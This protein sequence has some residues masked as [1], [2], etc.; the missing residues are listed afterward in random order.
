MPDVDVLLVGG[1]VASAA[2]ATQL[3][4]DG[5]TG[6]IMLVGREADPPYNRP[7]I[8]KGYLLGE[9]D[10]AATLVHDPAWYADAGV[11]L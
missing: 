4:E 9:E 11:E 1:G 10:R 2:C 8:S 5:F 6:S 7:P 3:R